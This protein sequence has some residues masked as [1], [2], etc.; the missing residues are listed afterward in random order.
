[1][2]EPRERVYQCLGDMLSFHIVLLSASEIA[3]TRYYRDHLFLFKKQLQKTSK[4][5]IHYQRTSSVAQSSARLC[6]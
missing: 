6:T 3:D 5:H 2:G 1:M 4:E